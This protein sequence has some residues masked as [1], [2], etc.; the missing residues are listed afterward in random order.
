MIRK[1]CRYCLPLILIFSFLLSEQVLA[2]SSNSQIRGTVYE[3]SSAGKKVPLPG[4]TVSIPAFGIGGVTSV[5]GAYLLKEV[6]NGKVRLSISFVGKVTIDTLLVVTKNQKL[7]FVLQDDD[8]RLKE[9]VVTAESNKSGQSTS[10]KISTTAMEHLQAVSL[11]DLMALLPGGITT[12]PSLS[13]ASQ[14]NIRSAGDDGNI[15]A[16]GTAIIQDG[17]PISNNA[18]LQVMNPSVKG[19]TFTLAG[20]ASPA[21]GFDTRLLSLE[22][23]E[24]VEVIR[25]VPSVAH[26]DLTSGAVLITSKAGRAPL[27][28][29]AR[30]NPK[31]YHFSANK[32]LAFGEKGGALNVNAEFAHNTSMPTSSYAYYERA[33]GKLLYSN[34]LWRG[35]WRTNTAVDVWYGRDKRDK[36]PDDAVNELESDGTNFR[37]ALNTNGTLNIDKGWLKS[38]KYVVSGSYFDKYSYLTQIHSSATAPY[39]MTNVDGAILADQPGRILYDVNGK[40]LTKYDG[41]DPTHYAHYLPSNYKGRYNIYGQELNLYV[42]TIATLFGQL[43]ATNHRILLGLDYRMDGN[44]GK[45]KVF[46]P[47][48]PPYRNLSALNA[49]FRPRAYRDVPFVHQLGLFAEENF[50]WNVLDRH[51]VKLQAGLRWDQISVVGGKLS[52]RANLSL[53]VVP[54]WLYLRGGYGIT[55]KMPTLLYIY[56]EK[57]YFEYININE[58]ASSLPDRAFMTTTRVFDTQNKDLQIATNRKA[59]VGLDLHTPIGRLMVTAYDELMENGYSLSPVHKPVQYKEYKRVAGSGEARFEEVGSNPVLA[60]YYSP[61]NNITSHRRG[62]EWDLKLNRIDAI[63]TSFAL[64]GAWMWSKVYNNGYE[65]YDDRSGAAAANRTHTALYEKGMEKHIDESITTSLRA[66]HNIP[67]LGM[68]LTLTAEAIWKEKDA[69][70][71][72]N[73]TIPVAYISKVDG[74][75]YP[76]DQTRMKEPEFSSL[77]RNRDDSKYIDQVLPPLYNFNFNLTKEIGDFM[78]LSFFANNMFRSYPRVESKRYPGSFISRNKSFYYGIELTFIIK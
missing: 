67:E 62:L 15:N 64:S 58:M 33:I 6:P 78:R 49:T 35:K 34:A 60:I 59:E 75:V 28:L 11:D 39:S 30:V 19:G 43:G 57:A 3:L 66:T 2:Q 44:L 9:V 53:E 40:P 16:L 12:N 63:R 47:H 38:L 76:F 22:G 51:M 65:Y 56:P 61:S 14:M 37:V 21:G 55:A 41:V 17:A 5:N 36:N 70:E 32:G 26:G 10:S 18:N 74:Q 77:L 54:D 52:P 20:G 29:K 7:D 1:V 4:A 25:G 71:M 31:L 68:V 69:F 48:F 73:D 42:N 24:S 46:S 45:G 50:S 8:F 23:I 27:V 13:Y 72:G